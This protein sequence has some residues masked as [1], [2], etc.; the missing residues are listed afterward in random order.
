MGAAGLLSLIDGVYSICLSHI[1]ALCFFSYIVLIL[2]PVLL[3]TW[4]IYTVLHFTHYEI[5]AGSTYGI[6]QLFSSTIV[7]SIEQ[8]QIMSVSS[9]WKTIAFHDVPGIL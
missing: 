6:L 3:S 5:V 1:F 8:T 2:P 7:V 9:F 4:V